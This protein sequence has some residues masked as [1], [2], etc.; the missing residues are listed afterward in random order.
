VRRAEELLTLPV[1]V[2]GIELGRTVDLIVDA[3]SS[4]AIGFDVRCGDGAHRFLPYAVARIG[5]A[6][7]V[8]DSPLVLL[9][10]GQVAFY[11]E[12]GTTLRALHGERLVIG[13]DGRLQ[14]SLV[15]ASRW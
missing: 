3:S 6:E 12:Q 8:I 5:D 14:E 4:R 13:P 11:R 9:D 10:F 15:S 1:R 2:N 7:I